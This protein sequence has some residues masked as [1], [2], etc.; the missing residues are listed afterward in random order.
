MSAKVARRRKLNVVYDCCG[1]KLITRHRI[2]KS[3][4]GKACIQL[5]QQS[6]ADLRRFCLVH[7]RDRYV[8]GLIK[9]DRLFVAADG[10]VGKLEGE[11]GGQR[12]LL[13]GRAER[14]HADI[15]IKQSVGGLLVL[16]ADGEYLLIAG[17][18]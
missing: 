15:G 16:V 4:L 6:G 1:D 8:V 2:G 14:H 10:I 18:P 9:R 13:F 17:S 11:G 5:G 3:G 7:G 12:D